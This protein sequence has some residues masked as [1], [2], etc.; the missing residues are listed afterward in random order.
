MIFMHSFSHNHGSVQIGCIRKVT[1]IGGTYLFTSMFMGGKVSLRFCTD[2][3]HPRD[4]AVS[5]I[6]PPGSRDFFC[7][8]ACFKQI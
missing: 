7:R 1:A 3:M 4:S 8:M 5:C 6:V 2:T